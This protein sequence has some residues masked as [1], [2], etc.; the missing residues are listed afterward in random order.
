MPSLPVHIEIAK[1]INNNDDFILGSILPDICIFKDINHKITHYNNP[2]KIAI[3]LFLNDY[4]NKLNNPIIQGYLVHL[5]T[6]I[7]F[8]SYAHK[9]YTLNENN[10]VIKQNDF[11]LY[12]NNFNNKIKISDKTLIYIKDLPFITKKDIYTMI[13][14]VNN[15]K[16]YDSTYKMFNK[17]ELDI[18]FNE[19]IIYIKK[20]LKNN[21]N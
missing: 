4:K 10:W 20:Y 12:G 1:K 5:L 14:K 3:D 7:Y 17:N 11:N 8:N 13:D 2:K 16:K 19:C 6:D 21:L 18:V 9:H 15:L